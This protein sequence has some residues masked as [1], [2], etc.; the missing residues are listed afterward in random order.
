MATILLFPTLGF[1]IVWETGV[2]K[3]TAFEN[4]CLSELVVRVP[5]YCLLAVALILIIDLAQFSSEKWSNLK[6]DKLATL[7]GYRVRQFFSVL[8]MVLMWV[9][10]ASFASLRNAIGVYSGPGY[11]ENEWGLGQIMAIMAWLPMLVG[12]A[13]IFFGKPQC[14]PLHMDLTKSLS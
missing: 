12:C 1:I 5:V 10:L 13:K 2:H 4:Y 14:I 11:S 7:K 6:D 9:S 3:Q 8:G